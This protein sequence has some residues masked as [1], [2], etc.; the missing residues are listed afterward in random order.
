MKKNIILIV[1][2]ILVVVLLVT[3]V[4]IK[5]PEEYY[6]THLD[7]ITED[8]ETVFLSVSCS[9]VLNNFDKLD[10]SLKENGRIPENGVIIEYKEFVLRKGDSVYDI[11]N[12]VLRFYKIQSE[13]KTDIDKGRYIA[14]I[15]HLYEFSCGELSGWLYKI[16][17]EFL[18][19][20]CG[21]AVL[22]DKDV[23]EIVYTCDLGMDVG[24]YPPQG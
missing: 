6:L 22:K 1:I 16:N 9:T 7:D 11:L 12:R 23:I 14:G 4:D 18:N 2:I 17:G 19:L 13:F 15:N 21:K 24:A 10:A 5:T 20:D 3:G 8:S